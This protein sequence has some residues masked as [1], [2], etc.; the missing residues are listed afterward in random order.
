MPGNA[1]QGVSLSL[2]KWTSLWGVKRK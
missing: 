1:G 2:V